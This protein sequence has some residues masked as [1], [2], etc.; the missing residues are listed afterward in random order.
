MKVNYELFHKI[1]LKFHFSGILENVILIGSW[2]LPIYKR[3]FADSPEIPILRTSD[4]DF[5]I[6]NPPKINNKIDIPKLLEE[7]EFEEQFSLLGNHTKFVHP[8]LEI[9]FLIPELGKSRNRS[10]LIKEYKV[11]AQPLRYLYFIQDHTL[12]INYSFAKLIVPEPTV[13]VLLKFLLTVKRKDVSKIQKDIATAVELS[14]FLL[15]KADQV[16][17][18]INIY[19]EMPKPWQRKLIKIVE[20]NSPELFKILSKK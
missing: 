13:F 19:A 18:F 1:L 20:E 14:D 8:D 7:F 15:K 17:K 12:E 16:E 9:E 2:V 5:L 3:Y 6:P 4:I 11:T 10:V